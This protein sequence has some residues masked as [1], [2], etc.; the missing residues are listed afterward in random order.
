[1]R[2]LANPKPKG[3][4]RANPHQAAFELKQRVVS[5]LNKLSDRDTYQI[6][7]EELERIAF[8]L[9]GPEPLAALLSCV[10]ETD[11]EQKSLVRKECVRVMGTLAKSHGAIVAPHLPKMVGSIV[12]RLKDSDS[13]VRDAC[14]ETVGVLASKMSGGD[15]MGNGCFVMLVKPLFEVLGEQNKQV[16]TGSALCLASIVDNATDPPAPV[17]LRMLVRSVKLMKNQHFMGKP[18]LIELLQSI[19]QA[20][21]ASTEQAMSSAMNSIQDALKSSDWT[22]RK[23]ASTAL[24][25]I[26]ECG[27]SSLGSFK[28]SCIRALESCRFD[29][30]KPVRDSVMQALQYWKKFPSLHSPEPSEVGSST[31]DNFIG[32]DFTDIAS[33]S[34]GGWKDTSSRKVNPVD[35]T[36]SVNK[37]APLA[38]KMACSNYVQS[39]CSQSSEWHV[40]ISLPRAHPPSIMDGLHEESEGSCI[41][42]TLERTTDDSTRFQ[43][44]DYD[45]LQMD[46]KPDCSPMSD[47][48]SGSC[49]TKHVNVLHDSLEHDNMVKKLVSRSA[50]GQT[51][52]EDHICSPT[53]Q[54]R[55]SMDSTVTEICSETLR[56]CCLHTANQLVLIQKQLLEIERKQSNFTDHLQVLNSDDKDFP[57]SLCYVREIEWHVEISLPRAHP[58]S[59]MDGLH[60]ESEGSCI[61][62]TLERTTDDSTR[63]QESDYDYL[64]MD[65]KPDCSPMSDFVSGSCDT[66]HVNVL[67]DSLEHDNMV[68]KLVSRSAAGQTHLED[69][70]CSP[71]TQKRGSMDSTVTEICS[72]TLRG[73]CLHTANQLVLIQ[74]QLLEIERKQSNFTDHLQVFMGGSMDSLSILQS[75]V[76]NLE[77]AVDGISRD[78]SHIGNYSNYGGSTLSK[79]NQS[80]S[81]SPRLSTCTPR[82][83][84][85]AYSRQSSVPSMKSQELWEETAPRSRLSTSVRENSELWGDPTS[86]ISKNPI[87]KCV[88]KSSARVPQ[89]SGLSQMRKADPLPASACKVNAN[90][91]VSESKV[92]FWKR[93]KDF[94]YTGDLESAY[95]EAL[96][97]GDDLLVIELMDTTGPVLERLSHEAASEILSTVV[98]RLA[99]QGFLS[100]MIP[101]LQ[102]ASNTAI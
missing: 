68:K 49:D 101:W 31:K 60:E 73:C 11:S 8:G 58:P 20:G 42:K 53:T 67:H 63:F 59:I 54:K 95:V 16:Q 26:A 89:N 22:T 19:I 27:G 39:R 86:D 40:E 47:F 85:D 96:Y 75:K 14:V 28:S 77:N 24:A 72:E 4:G 87:A 69:H 90:P 61:T 76:L 30:V 78:L 52:L 80:V 70:I 50:A 12:K 48:V 94:L 64:Q 15:D 33:V 41:T 10:L 84:V 62:K 23:S 82:S 93:V 55:G 83:S 102:Q 98:A 7:S 74:K 56:G 3:I 13:V 29:K 6:G 18:A 37:R 9:A 100:S 91:S 2:S 57:P 34:G 1:M 36:N 97:S 44:S 81:S 79:K 88:G 46:D 35:S 38:M 92:S 21:G 43:E 71:T 99:N 17:L 66:K 32:G 65:D 45:Y 5:A 25:G 51:H